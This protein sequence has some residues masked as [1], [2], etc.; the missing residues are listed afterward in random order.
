MAK[1]N[2]NGTGVQ[3]KSKM[4]HYRYA[5]I[6]N[7]DGVD[8]LST[9]LKKAFSKLDLVI[10]RYQEIKEDSFDDDSDD[11]RKAKLFINN[12]MPMYDIIFGDFMRYADGTNKSIVT[13]DN[14]AKYLKLEMIAPSRSK[15]GK[16]REFL[17]SILYFGVFKNHVAVIQSTILKTKELEKHL[18]WLLHKSNV[19]PSESYIYLTK[20]IP[21]T[22]QKKLDNSN[23]KV[24]KFGAPLVD[25]LDGQPLNEM[26]T[27]S[28]ESVDTKN[29]KYSPKGMGLNWLLSA[30]G[31]M[32]E[33]ERF[34]LSK[35][36]LSQD[37]LQ[38]SDLKVS[39]E[40][41]YTRKATKQSQTIIN[42]VSKAFRHVH[43]DEITIQYDKV[44]TLKGRELSLEKK[45]TV[46]FV[47]GVI[48]S[49]DLYPKIREWL[50][51]QID[52]DELVAEA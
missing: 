25:S 30:F 6:E 2:D 27:V 29:F 18:N 28:V 11:V 4:L 22:Q 13:I 37:A 50:K 9:M 52:V 40:V 12:A 8:S 33:L 43:P 14:N 48:D 38:G 24:L 19:L 35:E 51:E 17:D 31:D 32:K 41:S 16:R 26:A 3:Y 7:Y 23:T 34:G 45:L 1:E 46:K 5:S 15:D 42:Q 39:L 10:D 47:D 44:G 21:E 20:K 49:Q 36:I